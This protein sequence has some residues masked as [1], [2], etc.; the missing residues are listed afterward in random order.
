M[1]RCTVSPETCVRARPYINY[2]KSQTVAQCHITLLRMI[3]HYLEPNRHTSELKPCRFGEAMVR[4]I[5]ETLYIPPTAEYCT[6]AIHGRRNSWLAQ[7]SHCTL[8]FR[9]VSTAIFLTAATQRLMCDTARHP[10][11]L[12]RRHS[13][14]SRLI[15]VA[16]AASSPR[17]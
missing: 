7:R 14:A 15:L 2:R 10:V 16:V 13:P 4:R 17:E 1:P 3:T 8:A 9:H 12:V 6:R 5:A 11:Q